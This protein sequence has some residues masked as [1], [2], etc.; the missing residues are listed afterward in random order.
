MDQANFGTSRWNPLRDSIKPGETVVLKP[1][2]IRHIH[3]RNANGWQSILTHGSLIRSV[4]DYVFMALEG[5]GRVIVAD[6]PQTDACFDAIR[7]LLALDTLKEHY[8]DRGFV[9]DVLDLRREEWVNRGGVI[10]ERRKL[11]G[12]PR[13]YVAFDLAESSEFAG[14]E[15]GGH[16]Y[17][18]DYDEGEVNRHHTMGRREYLVSRTVIEADVVISLPKL[19]TH[20]KAGITVS[21]KNLVGINGDKNWLPHHTEA[22]R[23][24]G[25]ERPHPNVKSRMERMLVRQLRH[26][27]LTAPWVGNW[28][29][30]SARRAGIPVFGDTEEVIRSGNW[31]GNDTVWRMCLDIN[32]LLLYGNPDGTLRPPVPENRKRHLVVVDGIIA[33]QGRGPLNP[34]PFPAGLVAFGADPASVDAACAVLMGFDPDKIPIVRQA[35]QCRYYPIADGNWREVRVVSNQPEWNRLLSDIPY[36]STFH[37]DPHF[38]WRGHV[39]RGAA[40]EELRGERP[41]DAA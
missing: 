21:L 33:G 34:D 8:R 7:G 6:A 12:D 24:C 27:S 37:F 20:K 41:W 13:G 29:L 9:F 40:T 18:A 26:L 22:S 23:G 11:P 4:A 31:W 2:L 30:R 32:K 25:D 16:Y 3:P 36:E 39:E 14:H 1:N 35:F 17:G 28:I 38:G 5:R 15:G 19:K 10:V